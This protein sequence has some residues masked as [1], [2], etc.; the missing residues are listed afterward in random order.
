MGVKI[1]IE[2]TRFKKS[3]G[4][5]MFLTDENFYGANRDKCSLFNELLNHAR[6]NKHP[7]CCHNCN[8]ATWRTRDRKAVA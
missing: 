4:E 5:C 1:Q 6:G 2:M 8:L 3:C 7:Y